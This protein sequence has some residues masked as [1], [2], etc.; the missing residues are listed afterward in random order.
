MA[1][2]KQE[3]SPLMQQRGAEGLDASGLNRLRTSCMLLAASKRT[4]GCEHDCRHG[5]SRDMH[6]AHQEHQ[7]VCHHQQPIR[8]YPYF[9]PAVRQS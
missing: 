7:M 5:G 4:N 6:T 1:A 8:T 2:A 3:Y 9:S